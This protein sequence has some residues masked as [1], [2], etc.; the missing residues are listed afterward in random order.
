MPNAS[1]S[2]RST[3]HRH[4]APPGYESNHAALL[5]L[6]RFGPAIWGCSQMMALLFHAERSTVYGKASDQH[7]ETQALE[8]IYS[9]SQF[10]WVRG[11]WGGS[12]AAWYKANADLAINPEEPASTP[13]G[14]LRLR[15]S[16]RGRGAVVDYELDWPAVK[17]RIEKWKEG[18]RLQTLSEE[19]GSKFQTLKGPDFGPF[20]NSQVPSNQQTDSGKGPNFGPTVQKTSSPDLNSPS[21]AAFREH[22]NL[23]L[24]IASSERPRTDRPS[25]L[26]LRA[27]AKLHLPLRVIARFLHEKAENFRSRKYAFN[28]LLLA[29]AFTQEIIPWLKKNEHFVSEC[30]RNEQQALDRARSLRTTDSLETKSEIA[31]VGFAHE[32]TTQVQSALKGRKLR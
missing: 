24:E 10:R 27:N 16:G 5:D 17:R 28:P 29:K 26:I 25:E 32:L 15:R 11:P 4:T 20:Q 9:S 30:V 31:P 12:R 21:D 1:E 23:E 19:E 3:R 8:G 13:N 7:S 18:S 14:V 22:V 2:P 6:V